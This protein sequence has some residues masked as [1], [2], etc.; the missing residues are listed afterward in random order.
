M[1]DDHHQKG[2]GLAMSAT[3]TPFETQKKEARS[4]HNNNN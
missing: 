4:S 2:E 1:I 3:T